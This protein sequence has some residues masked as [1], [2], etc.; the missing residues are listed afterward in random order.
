M[1]PENGEM[2]DQGAGF[3]I[4]MIPGIQGRWEWQRPAFEALARRTRTIAYSLCGEPGSQG[5]LTVAGGFDAHVAQ[6]DGVLQRC[7]VD[8]VALCGV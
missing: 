3:P 1:R 6:L 8:R 4:V 7:G 2:V 5:R